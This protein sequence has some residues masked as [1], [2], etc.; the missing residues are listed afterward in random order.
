MNE[1]GSGAVR[2][3]IKDMAEVLGPGVEPPSLLARDLVLVG[4]TIE[5]NLAGAGGV[6]Q[7]RQ[8][9]VLATTA[10]ILARTRR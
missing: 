3:A 7:K 8:R 1:G 9:V 5:R 6:R 4:S 2:T 10:A